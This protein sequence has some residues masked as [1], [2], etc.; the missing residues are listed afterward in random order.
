MKKTLITTLL[1]TLA[2][3]NA[4]AISIEDFW[5]TI[6][7]SSTFSAMEV[8]REDAREKHFDQLEIALSETITAGDLT[9]IK[10]D[11]ATIPA[12]YKLTEVE[13]SGKYVAIYSTPLG[14]DKALLLI[15]VLEKNDGVIIKGI[16]PQSMIDNELSDFSLKD[17]FK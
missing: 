6:K 13:D 16:C 4:A 17:I 10:T 8:P 2:A 3:I 14:G 15:V 12:A 9:K 1:L 11:V 5:N 7:A